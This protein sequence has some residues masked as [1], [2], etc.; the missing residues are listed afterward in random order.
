MDLTA[1]GGSSA[2]AEWPFFGENTEGQVPPVRTIWPVVS[3]EGCQR[4]PSTH[5]S[6]IN[7]DSVLDRG[8]CQPERGCP[9]HPCHTERHA[10]SG[11]DRERELP[12]AIDAPLYGAGYDR[13]GIHGGQDE[14]WPVG[15]RG[16]RSSGLGP[17]GRKTGHGGRSMQEPENG[18]SGIP[19]LLGTSA[20]TP[21]FTPWEI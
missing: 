18:L 11:D 3:L 12:G 13:G 5:P 1:Y 17:C 10:L 4:S 9:T 19:L 15:A 2:T 6:V 8:Y 16:S 7:E 14:A 21:S 20:N